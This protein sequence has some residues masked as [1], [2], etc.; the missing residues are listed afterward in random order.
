MEDSIKKVPLINQLILK[1]LDEKSRENF[2]KA[3]RGADR[4]LDKERIYWILKMNKYRGNFKE[5]KGSW[6][7][8]NC[9][10]PVDNVKQLAIAVEKFFNGLAKRIDEQWHPLF[11]AAE[12]G[13]L[14]LCNMIIEKTNNK[15]PRRIKDEI[16]PQTG[17]IWSSN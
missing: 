3:S 6:K 17:R 8:G 14:D 11:I 16:T 10:I 4:V 2:K 9:Q 13:S 5:F 1:N 15:N 12:Q 7:M